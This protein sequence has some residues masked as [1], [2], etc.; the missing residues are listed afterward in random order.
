MI[1]NVTERNFAI[2]QNAM[3]NVEP[4]KCTEMFFVP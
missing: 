1:Q 2:Q 3:A 4:F